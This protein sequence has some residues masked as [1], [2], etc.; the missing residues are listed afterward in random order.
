VELG[1][2]STRYYDAIFAYS[3]P[4]AEIKYDRKNVIPPNHFGYQNETL[5]G[6]LLNNSKYLLVNDQARRLNPVMNPEFENRWS[7]SPKDFERI[8]M[9]SRINQVYSNKDLEIFFAPGNAGGDN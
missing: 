5:L 8:K 7:F 2:T 4:R 6:N 9:D 3:A 1:L